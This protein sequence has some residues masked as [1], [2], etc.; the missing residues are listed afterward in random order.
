MLA[1]EV[2]VVKWKSLHRVLSHVGVDLTLS[3]QHGATW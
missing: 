1:L 3:D 2:I